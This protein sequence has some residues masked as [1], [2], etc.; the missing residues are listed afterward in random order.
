[1]A[2]FCHISTQLNPYRSFRL[3]F[4]YLGTLFTRL[5]HS[6]C[7]LGVPSLQIRRHHRHH[8]VAQRLQPQCTLD[9]CLSQVVG[10]ADL[11][12]AAQ[13]SACVS[14]FGAP[15]TVTLTNAADVIFSTSTV[16]V[17]YTDIIISTSTAFSTVTEA[18]TSYVDVPQTVTEYTATRIST[19]IIQ[20][21][22]PAVT[23]LRKRSA[24]LKNRSGCKPRSSSSTLPPQEPSITSTEEPSATLPAANC[25]DLAQYSSACSCIGAISDA[26]QIATFSDAAPTSFITETFTSTAAAS[27]ST[28]VITVIVTETETQVATTTIPTTIQTIEDSVE[29]ATSTIP[30]SLAPTL[31]AVLRANLAN[32]LIKPLGQYL[33]LDGAAT[34]ATS[35]NVQVITSSGRLSFLS[36]PTFSLWVRGNNLY[37]Y[38]WLQPDSA[39]S[40]DRPVSC[41]PD[42]NGVLNCAT[43]DGVFNVIYFCSG[44]V[45]YMGPS[46]WNQAGCTKIVL[47]LNTV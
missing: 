39:A 42:I 25:I 14:L 22:Q 17:P 36:S 23:L 26:T 12:P 7:C 38:L 33:M 30:A 2:S 9:Q 47:N 21:T 41:M 4:I 28:S 24:Q 29:T 8:V 19:E 5:Y 35:A 32:R 10:S 18:A 16:T 20:A 44:T 43:A 6:S 31:T 13:F 40:S 15:A 34:A 11:N 45:L 1:M 37:G 27:T 46:D 3:V